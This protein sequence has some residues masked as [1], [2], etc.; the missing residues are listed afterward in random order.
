[1]TIKLLKHFIKEIKSPVGEKHYPVYSVTNDRG[2]I[3]SEDQFGKIVY[4][5][6]TKKYKQV[7]KGFFAYNPSRINVGSIAVNHTNFTCSVSPMYTVF[8][9]NEN[10]L[11]PEYLLYFL[12]S[13]LG[14][15]EINRRTQGTV[16]FQLKFDSLC[17]IPIYIPCIQKQQ[18]IV[19]LLND[20]NALCQKQKQALDLTK[21]MIPSLFYDMF[22]DPTTNH[23]NWA[24]LPLK[25]V[26]ESIIYGCSKKAAEVSIGIPIIRMNNVTY[27]GMLKLEDLKFVELDED[28]KAKFF[29]QKG[30]VLFN[31]TNSRELVGKTALW[32][33][34]I[35]AVFASYFIRLRVNHSILNPHYLSVYMNL[36]F[37]KRCLKK[38]AR[39][40]IGQAN[41]N[42]KELSSIVIMIPL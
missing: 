42:A 14:Q 23:L 37:M 15:A 26:L 32:T 38:M 19:D 10:E 36:P 34:E 40:A 30:D 41:I 28:E 11:L 27:E 4:S 2:F 29:L 39:G 1:M 21:Q 3:P 5:K 16:R 25:R 31:R 33:N 12:K 8:A 9:C 7:E 22:G 13:H 24:M 6:N 35:P 18:K 20:L 17:K